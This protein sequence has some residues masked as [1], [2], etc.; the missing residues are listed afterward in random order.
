MLYS[1]KLLQVCIS[2]ERPPTKQ[3]KTPLAQPRRSSMRFC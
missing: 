1:I 3:K 2:S